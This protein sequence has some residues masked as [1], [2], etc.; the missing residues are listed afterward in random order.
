MVCVCVLVQEKHDR[1]FAVC[2]SATLFTDHL[3][4]RSVTYVFINNDIK[5]LHL[6][7][8]LLEPLRVCIGEESD[9]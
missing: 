1:A 6:L 8:V 9:H 7:R 5:L 3:L 4:Q 2:Y